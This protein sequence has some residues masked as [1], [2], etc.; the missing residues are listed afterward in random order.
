M[1]FNFNKS[2][3]WN[4][5]KKKKKYFDKIIFIKLVKIECDGWRREEHVMD[6]KEFVGWERARTFFWGWAHQRTGPPVR[7]CRRDH[8]HILSNR[9]LQ[10]NARAL[11]NSGHLKVQLRWTQAKKNSKKRHIYISVNYGKL[12]PSTLTDDKL[13]IFS[14]RKHSFKQQDQRPTIKNILLK[15]LRAMS[16]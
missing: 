10:K 4:L 5:I 12:L 16:K 13:Y 9:Y 11:N 3:N 14:E 2:L 1:N 15:L 8:R 6:L 7:V